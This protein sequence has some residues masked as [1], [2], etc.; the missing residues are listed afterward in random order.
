MMTNEIVFA[1]I[2]PAAAAP[3]VALVLHCGPKGRK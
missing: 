1:K 2:V 3:R